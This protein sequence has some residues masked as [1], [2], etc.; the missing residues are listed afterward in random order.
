MTDN[1][2]TGPDEFLTQLTDVLKSHRFRIIKTSVSA[3]FIDAE[4][5]ITGASFVIH[6]ADI[7]NAPSVDV[8]KIIE[9]AFPSFKCT[10]KDSVTMN[11]Y[12]MTRI[13]DNDTSIQPMKNIL[14]NIARLGNLDPKCDYALVLKLMEEVGELSECFN[15]FKGNLPHKTMKEN[16]EGEAADVIICAIAI[17]ARVYPDLNPDSVIQMIMKQL[18]LK[19]EKWNNVIDFHLGPEIHRNP[20]TKI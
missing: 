4:R 15:H 17:I 11:S 9:A 20:V 7:N 1:T 8:E 3:S 19:S 13:A 16:I 5:F 18:V 14:A 6:F 12:K 2:L 10:M